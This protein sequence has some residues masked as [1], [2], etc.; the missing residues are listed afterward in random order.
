M[1]YF[2][3]IELDETHADA[4]AAVSRCFSGN[5]YSDH[6]FLWHFFGA[7]QG[8]R[9]DFLFRRFEPQGIRQQALFYC[10]ST[11][12]AT[13]PHPAWR[14]ETR[15][16]APQ[17]QAGERLMFDLRANPTSVHKRDGKAFRDDV[18]MDA[19]RRIAAEHSVGRWSDVPAMHR[20]LLYDV[21]QA[22][23]REWLDGRQSHNGFAGRHGFRVLDD[24]RVDAYRQHRIGRG[25][26]AAISLSTVDLSGTLEVIDPALLAHGLLEGMGRAK[27]FGCGLM[28]V[29]R[30]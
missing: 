17:I 18:V 15:E 10:L 19:K 16:Y 24:L 7:P 26:A 2:T 20:P 11:R 22:A 6:Q 14:V 9:R 5:A 27:A 25:E 1:K 30:A 29:R 12:P 23:V 3:R 4:R 13:A 8:T 21:A 28:L